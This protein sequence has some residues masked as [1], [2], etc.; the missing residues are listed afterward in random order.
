MVKYLILFTLFLSACA[1]L[2]PTPQDIE[3]K[4]FQPAP[5]KAVIYIVR[6]TLDTFHS[7]P[8]S[9]TGIGSLATMQGT[10][11]RLEAAPGMLQIQTFG[12]GTS[13]VTLNAQAG[14]IYYVMHNAAGSQRHGLSSAWVRQVDA[15]TGQRMVLQAQHI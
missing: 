3:A 4:K 5:G 7:A 10:Y 13:S 9:I 12:A 8:L 1:Q 6:P 2:P 14:Q 11:L 15:Q